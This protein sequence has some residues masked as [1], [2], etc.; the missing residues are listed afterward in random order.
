MASV[1]DPKTFSQ[2]TFTESNSTESTPVP[3]GEWPGII[4]KCEITSWEKR[5]KT[6]AGLKYTLMIEIEDPAVQAVTGRPK[7]LVRRDAMLDLTP[8]GGLDF[9]KGMNTNLGRDREAVGLNRP[10]QPFAFDMFVGRPCKVNVTHRA[11]DDGRLVAEAKA[12]AAI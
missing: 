7:S 5:D 1:F 9:G 10:G 6:A 11:L 12:I 3:V 2:M 8:E 4:T